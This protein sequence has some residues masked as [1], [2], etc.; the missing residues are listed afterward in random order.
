M[1]SLSWSSIHITRDL[2]FH[3]VHEYFYFHYFDLGD[4]SLWLATGRPSVQCEAWPRVSEVRWGQCGC[5]QSGQQQVETHS[6]RRVQ[7]N[8]SQFFS[9]R[10]LGVPGYGFQIKNNCVTHSNSGQKSSPSF[11]FVSSNSNVTPSFNGY[12]V[13]NKNSYASLNVSI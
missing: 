6:S 7:G 9:T 4:D 8:Y 1:G 12:V 5:H 13:F 3:H 2:I 10:H 11:V